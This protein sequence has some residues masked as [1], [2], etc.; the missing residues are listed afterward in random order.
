MNQ[1]KILCIVMDN[2]KT[3]PFIFWNSREFT[4]LDISLNGIIY[5]FFTSLLYT[6]FK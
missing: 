4:D 6:F 2:D 5:Y 3:Y 1:I